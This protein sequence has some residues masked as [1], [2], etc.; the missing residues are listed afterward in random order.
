MIINT[1]EI[2]PSPITSLHSACV[3]NPNALRIDAPGTSMSRPYLWS[4]NVRN[5][6]SLTMSASNP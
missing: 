2:T 6:T 4:I 3:S 5:V 1:P